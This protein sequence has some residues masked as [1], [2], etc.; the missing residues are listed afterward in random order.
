MRLLL[1]DRSVFARRFADAY[2]EVLY[3]TDRILARM[4]EI[5]AETERLRKVA[6]HRVE[7]MEQHLEERKEYIS[8]RLEPTGSIKNS[9]IRDQDQLITMLYNDAS[10]TDEMRSLKE[11]IDK[12]RERLDDRLALLPV[13]PDR[14]VRKAK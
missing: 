14:Q 5:K 7:K 13:S 2:P 6:E 3:R 11:N 4:N 1:R 12:N 10:A 9:L 8:Y